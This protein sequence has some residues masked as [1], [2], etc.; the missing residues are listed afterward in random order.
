MSYD[1]DT[2]W[3]RYDTY[4]QLGLYA[5]TWPAVRGHFS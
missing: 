1:S 3:F 5:V 4:T 2:Y